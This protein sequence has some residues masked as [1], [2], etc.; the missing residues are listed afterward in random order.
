MEG[1]ELMPLLPPTSLT[2][3]CARI[4]V[5]GGTGM[6]AVMALLGCHARAPAGGGQTMAWH[7]MAGDSGG[8]PCTETQ[9]TSGAKIPTGQAPCIPRVDTAFDCPF[10]SKFSA[11]APKP[12]TPV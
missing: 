9:A 3:V 12:S 2:A 7:R 8:V 1:R 11:I 5:A 10:Y 6:G 4:E